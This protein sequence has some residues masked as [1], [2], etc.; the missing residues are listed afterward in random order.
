MLHQLSYNHRRSFES[1]ENFLVLILYKPRKISWLFSRIIPKPETLSTAFSRFD[2]PYKIF[3]IQNY[4]WAWYAKVS[5][6]EN[7]KDEYAQ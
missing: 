1:R 5:S 6:K 7:E 3:G 2:R 4:L